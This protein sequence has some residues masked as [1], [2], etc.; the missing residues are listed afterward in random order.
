MVSSIS[1]DIGAGQYTEA[2]R[3]ESADFFLGVHYHK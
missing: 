3:L 1:V 2:C